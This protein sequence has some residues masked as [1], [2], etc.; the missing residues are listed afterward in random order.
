MLLNVFMSDHVQA[1]Y[2]KNQSA[3]WMGGRPRILPVLSPQLRMHLRR[4]YQIRSLDR[5]AVGVK[6]FGGFGGFG[7]PRDHNLCLSFAAMYR[8]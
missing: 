7:D 5:F 3:R 2:V 8:L 1:V 4:E 6:K